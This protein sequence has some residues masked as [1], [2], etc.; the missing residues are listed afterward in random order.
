MANQPIVY[1]AEKQCEGIIK[2]TKSQCNNRA[3]YR[4][5]EIIK[6]GDILAEQ[7]KYCCG[8]HSK[9]D[10]RLELPKNPN[11]GELYNEQIKQRLIAA[12]L[13]KDEN[14]RVGRYGKVVVSKMLMMKE[15]T[16]IAGH[17]NIYPNYKHGSRKDGMGC[18]TLSPKSII[19]IPHKMFIKGKT[20]EEHIYLPIAKNSQK[21]SPAKLNQSATQKEQFAPKQSNIAL[22]N[23]M[24]MNRIAIN[25]HPK[26]SR[27]RILPPELLT[28]KY[29]RMRIFRYFR[30]IILWMD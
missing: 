20:P 17:I 25:S 30:Y 15:P 4:S 16:H 24:M 22:K 13:A 1:Y 3:Y 9:K 10:N 14:V 7:T 5:V 23:I 11:S 8:V 12:E 18:S 19:N 28:Q 2:S 26:K 27:N 21:Y 29:C 6:N